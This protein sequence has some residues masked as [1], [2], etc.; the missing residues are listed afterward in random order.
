M[1]SRRDFLRAT[2]TKDA[3]GRMIATPQPM[4]DSSLLTE[5]VRSQALLIREPGAPAA[6]KGEPCR[7]LRLPGG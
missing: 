2:L 4:Q 5:L 1:K 6:R 7:I 3:Q